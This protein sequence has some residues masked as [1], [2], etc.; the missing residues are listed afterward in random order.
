FLN[1]SMP[2]T[3]I[4]QPLHEIGQQA[5]NLLFD[6]IEGKTAKTGKIIFTE[7]ELVVRASSLRTLKAKKRKIQNMEVC[8]V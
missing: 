5:N 3:S 2:L 6:N 4:R 7:P 1:A 8:H